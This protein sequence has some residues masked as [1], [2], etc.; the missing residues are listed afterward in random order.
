M[1]TKKVRGCERMRDDERLTG[2]REGE[3]RGRDGKDDRRM[4]MMMMMTTMVFRG[5]MGRETKG[6]WNLGN[7]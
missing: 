2:G 3:I 7:D 6:E 4:M 1:S 5:R